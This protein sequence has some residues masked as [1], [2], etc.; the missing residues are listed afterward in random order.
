MAAAPY[1]I[2]LDDDLRKALERE[3]EIEDRTAAQ[4]A[5]RAIRSMLEAKASKRDALNAA[6]QR[7][8]QGRFI[9]SGAM[10]AWLESWDSEEERPAPQ[11][12]ILP[13]DR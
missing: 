11:P 1:S 2:R 3:A 10:N 5:V 12:D 8:E 6:L 9:S 7:A 4:L 13:D